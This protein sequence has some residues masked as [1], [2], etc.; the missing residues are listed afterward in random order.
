MPRQTAAPKTLVFPDGFAMSISTD[1]TT[2]TDVGVLQGGGS[3]TFNW[4]DFRIDAGNYRQL[5]DKYIDPQIAL[6]PS[7]VLDFDPAKIVALFP[8][9]MSS[10]AATIPGTGTD[11][12]Y[13]GTERYG[14]LTRVYVKLSHYTV[15]NSA[16]T[17]TDT[18]I[19]WEFVL[20]NAKVDAGGSIT[21]TGAESSDLSSVSVSFTGEPDPSDVS[22]FFNFYQLTAV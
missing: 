1:G 17:A 6:A 18:D 10:A 13:A 8:G 16:G 15:D 9:F 22:K 4:T 11:L 5:V 2:Y 19:D 3:I 7:P 14:T 21:I 20:S 12:S